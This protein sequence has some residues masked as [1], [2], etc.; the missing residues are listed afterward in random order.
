MEG[1]NRKRL[2][3]NTV[4]LYILTFSNY[5]LSLAVVPYETRILG[6]EVYGVLG[7]ATAIMV[8]FQLVIDFGFL[9]SATQDVSRNRED[10]GF[11]SRTFTAVT[12]CKGVLVLFSGAVLA[13]LVRVIPAWQEH[14]GIYLL[15]FLGTALNGLIPDYLY[16]GLEN[17][18]AITI[19]TVC[20]KAFFTACILL[21]MK[22][23]ADLWMAPAATAVGNGAAALVCV[24][25]V[26][27]RFGIRFCRVGV[28][29][30]GDH[31]KRSSVFFYSR[32]AT[33]AYS[34][35]NTII[36]DL[37]SAGGAPT[38][39][40]TAAD[41]LM[42]TGKSAVSPISDSMYPYMVKHR[43]FKLV[44]KVLLIAEPLIILFCAGVF[45]FAE[46]FCRL[47]FGEEFAETG[48][49]LRA[50]LPVG[51]VILPSYILGFP[52]LSAMG[53]SKYAN[54]SVIAGSAFHLA[55]M[56][57]LYFTGNMNMITLGLAVSA[58]ECVI[59]GIRVAV[60]VR[61]RGRMKEER[62]ECA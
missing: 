4:M 51:V 60:V 31:L 58:T 46:P 49:V 37:I 10:K 8:Y 47:V 14:A 33:T 17:M 35:L 25:D 62:D 57:A 45:I 21:F 23:P 7:V 9:M 32:I 2:L 28:R 15:F 22:S 12:L 59:L 48:Q 24:F 43:D 20:I 27:R 41:K 39:F 5:F 18:A 40:Y 50:M 26:K 30:M 19:R 11:L 55:V 29:E 16:R 54:T 56:A 44:K 38:S 6:K 42:T 13:V 3:K 36:L 1:Q 61:C 52:T 34:A 53:L